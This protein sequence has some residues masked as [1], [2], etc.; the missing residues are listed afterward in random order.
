MAS[1]DYVIG[2]LIDKTDCSKNRA[3]C[4]SMNIKPLMDKIDKLNEKFDKTSEKTDDKLEKVLVAMAEMPEKIIEK[5]DGRYA[6]KNI[7]DDVKSIRAKTE[8]HMYEWLK[9]VITA[10]IGFGLSYL[11]LKIK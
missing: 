9:Y 4:Y 3:E 11:L 6:V 2:N 8:S 1:Q 10:L 5:A 7:E